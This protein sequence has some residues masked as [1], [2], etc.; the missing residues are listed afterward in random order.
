M[1]VHMRLTG[2]KA[3]ARKMRK[4]QAEAVPVC[5]DA[6]KEWADDVASG[7]K[8]SVPVDTTKLQRKI[9][10]R[11]RAT[12]G[13]VIAD[14]SYAQYVELGTSRQ[15]AQPFLYPAFAAHRD[16]TPYVRTALDKR[17]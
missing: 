9:K 8:T 12:S 15:E 6:I 7:A 17:L 16:V 4:L 2:D 10:K 13:E 11:V 5:T 3:L 1:A 14:T